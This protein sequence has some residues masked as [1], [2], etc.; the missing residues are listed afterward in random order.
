MGF[1]KNKK[2]KQKKHEK[3]NKQ[4]KKKNIALHAFEEAVEYVVDQV[5]PKSYN[6]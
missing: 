1:E 5:P 6:S 3:T 4:T 2:K